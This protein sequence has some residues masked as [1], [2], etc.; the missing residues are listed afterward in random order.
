[1]PMISKIES[2]MEDKDP[3]DLDGDGKFGPFEMAILDEEEKNRKEGDGN[4][5]GCC[6]IFLILGASARVS[7]WA[8]SQF[9]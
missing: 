5:S 8:L 1:M 4:K 3:F 9:I 6:F 7:Y 2:H